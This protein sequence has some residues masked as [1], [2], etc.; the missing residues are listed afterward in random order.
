MDMKSYPMKMIIEGIREDGSNFRPSDWIERLS[1]TMGGFGPDHRLC[2][3]NKVQPA[4]ISGIK[5][6]VVDV[7]LKEENPAAYEYLL[8]FA[9]SNHL[10]RRVGTINADYAATPN[11][12]GTS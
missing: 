8:S 7:S 12:L 6:L 4:V 1:A 10:R 3:S 2:Y 5:C 11:Y 9:I